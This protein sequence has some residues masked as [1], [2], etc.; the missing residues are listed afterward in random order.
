VTSPLPSNP[1]S[2]RKSS[3]STEG[4]CVEVAPFP[5]GNIAIRNS[6]HPTSGVTVFTRDEMAAFLQGVKAG[7]FDNMT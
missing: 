3:Y 7:E 4:N 6:K 2:W 5:D 1:L